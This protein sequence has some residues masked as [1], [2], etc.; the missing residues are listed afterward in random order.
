M[1][2]PAI[3]YGPLLFNDPRMGMRVRPAQSG[4]M[5]TRAAMRILD[6]MLARPGNRAIAAPAIG[7][8]LRY[9]A[10]RRG[11]ELLHVLGP[12]L[13]AASGFHLNRAET[14]P[15]TGPMR[16]HAWR[17]AKV[18]LT[19]TQPSGL[20][21]SEDL[22]GALAISVQQAM[23]LLDSG[24]PFDWITPFHRSWADSASPVIRARSEGLNRALHL[25]PWRGDAEVAGPLVALDPQRVQVLDDA[26]AP[27]AVLDAANPS[28]PL[29]ALGRRCL[30]I[31]SA[32]SALQN[33]M[34]LTPGLTPLAV[35]LLS[36]LPDLTLH[37]GPGWPLRAMTAL[38]LA[39]GCRVA[40]LSDPTADE[41]APRMD[42]IL[43]EGDADW[44]HGAEAP[45]LMRGHARRL[46]GGAA[47]LLV[48]YPG[49]AP[50]VED[51]LQSIFP[52]LYAL[53]DPQA[54]T[55]YVAAR[56]RLDL[57]AA[58]SRAMRRAGEWRQ[59]E[60]LRQATE[61][62]QLIVKSGERRAP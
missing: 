60:L 23:E 46:T 61:G 5:A 11:A 13:S 12:Q 51:L 17:A 26:G 27:V 38:Q 32:T 36:I 50:K 42:A 35:A 22:D 62:W 49:P 15:A 6:D 34:V 30:G 7:L 39:S 10:L 2:D 20:P 59:P 28:R 24:A 31:L 1:T 19:G 40:S 45:A 54:G 16:R 47:V 3:S 55:I 56:A 53:D 29:C 52:A 14:T 37:H 9:L 43:L 41:T 44:L 33:V 18:T 25:A 57:P 8:P 21:V 58:C 4:D 48:C